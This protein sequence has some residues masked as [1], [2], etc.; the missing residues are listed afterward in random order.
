MSGGPSRMVVAALVAIA[1]STAAAGTTSAAIL[2]NVSFDDPGGTFAP[3]YGVIT[4]HTVAAGARWATF[5]D[6]IPFKL[7]SPSAT[8]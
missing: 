1:L 2:Y 7:S 8:G 3:Y 6:G 4:S 5:L